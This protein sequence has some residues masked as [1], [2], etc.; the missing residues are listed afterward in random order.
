[1]RFESDLTPPHPTPHPLLP[2]YPNLKKK[3]L[4]DFWGGIR[5]VGALLDLSIF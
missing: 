5:I 4:L 2:N 1:M 3:G